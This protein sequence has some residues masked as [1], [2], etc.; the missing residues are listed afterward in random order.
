MAK[1]YLTDSTIYSVSPYASFHSNVTNKQKRIVTLGDDCILGGPGSFSLTPGE[2]ATHVIL[3]TGRCVIDD[4]LI[5]SDTILNIDLMDS[6]NFYNATGN[7]ASEDG[8]FYFCLDYT[9]SKSRP[10]PKCSVQILKP[11]ETYKYVKNVS[12]LI[13]KV[14]EVSSGVITKYYD[15]DSTDLNNVKGRV[16]PRIYAENIEILPE[17][18][19]SDIGRFV[20]VKDSSTGVVT[21]Y[22][23]YEAE[24]VVIGQ[25]GEDED[26]YLPIAS[27]EEPTPSDWDYYVGT[28]WVQVFDNPDENRI[29]ILVS[30]ETDN[31]V[32]RSTSVAIT[33]DENP[34]FD[35]DSGSGSPSFWVNQVSGEMF[36]YMQN[37]SLENIYGNQA[38]WS[39]IT[40]TIVHDVTF[41]IDPSAGDNDNQLPISDTPFLTFSRMSE[42]LSGFNIEE[43]KTVTII[44][45]EGTHSVSEPITI[46]HPDSD[47]IIIQSESPEISKTLS[48]VTAST[49]TSLVLQLD[50]FADGVIASGDYA[51]ILNTN[52]T[53]VEATQFAALCG[54]YQIT[55]VDHSANTITI[56]WD[57]ILNRG[58][59]VVTSPAGD[60]S[61]EVYILKTILTC[62]GTNGLEL[63]TG[64][65][66]GGLKNI[67]LIGNNTEDSFGIAIPRPL[68]SYADTE[69]NKSKR[70]GGS[71][72]YMKNVGIRGFGIGLYIGPG[73]DTFGEN[74]ACTSN[75]TG[76]Y[77]SGG[78][79]YNISSSH[80][81]SSVHASPI[82]EISD[83]TGCGLYFRGG[84]S[85]TDQG[86]FCGNEK[87][88][89]RCYS[90]EAWATNSICMNN[91][92]SGFVCDDRG[93]LG[94]SPMNNSISLSEPSRYYF[95]C[96][97]AYNGFVA[98][99]NS[100]LRANEY[101][102]FSN[103]WQGICAGE[104]SSIEAFYC[105]SYNN[106]D[107][108]LF[109]YDNSRIEASTKSYRYKSFNFNGISATSNATYCESGSDNIDP[110]KVVL[111]AIPEGLE[112]FYENGSDYAN[113]YAWGNSY[114]H[115]EN[116]LVRGKTSGQ[117]SIV[118][119][120]GMSSID[121]EH[122]VFFCRTLGNTNGI[123]AYSGSKV[124]CYK[125]VSFNCSEGFVSD[126]Q[127]TFMDAS[128]AVSKDHSA[129][130][131][132]S[133][134]SGTMDCYGA[135][136][137]NNDY[138]GFYAEEG[139]F[140]Y[141]Q[142]SSTCNCFYADILANYETENDFFNDDPT[143]HSIYS[144]LTS[145]QKGNSR[146]GYH[147]KTSS[148]IQCTLTFSCD[149]TYNAYGIE[150][151][152]SMHAYRARAYNS[153]DIAFHG[154]ST[155]YISLV[156][157]Y[158]ENSQ[159]SEGLRLYSNST[160]WFDRTK[161]ENCGS[162]PCFKISRRSY[163]EMSQCQAITGSYGY[164]CEYGSYIKKMSCTY[165][166][167]GTS[168]NADGTSII[169]SS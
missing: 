55:S 85:I 97:N 47:K 8:L 118:V 18:T 114:I 73:S 26:V 156:V 151:N 41:Y 43:G 69:E 125:G 22:L 149:N 58:H 121:G 53:T 98:Y 146:N 143:A 158:S 122:C 136:S 99:S 39:R 59:T 52:A 48:H 27:T 111:A 95:S 142:S 60:I 93:F 164:Q 42:F 90:S 128:M 45:P 28:V 49:P 71:I 157:C 80:S 84:Y 123:I 78:R 24:W 44:V 116:A 54:C 64:K 155:A 6:N 5:E 92:G 152:S 133:R 134:H 119:S 56:N 83:S 40:R 153:G 87:E 1:T 82:G 94:L 86:F 102:A 68:V 25:G 70:N 126:G 162:N 137:F 72:S 145:S 106:S 113:I 89:V 109:A 16:Y 67:A 61:G 148:I 105:R 4:V 163:A 35:T 38:N 20:C 165:T 9:Y 96:N 147:A 138:Y 169:E 141:A 36:L 65:Q 63:N 74:I 57:G 15:Q 17:W 13:I 30:N 159:F 120:E 76:M 33:R 115:I 88:G 104:G 66:L 46:D 23:G 32:W 112:E 166:G 51:L 144:S 135:S 139:G 81:N 3:G 29:F 131:F 12:Y 77:L 21:Y 124:Y 10:A 34:N 132:C 127:N 75:G 62:V 160:G 150:E 50:D 14:L 107:C 154:W 108:S 130:G 100:F 7:I 37:D 129:S 91:G 117:W 103:G 168:D 167:S 2:D 31:A 110:Y 161:I 140:M 79:L 101:L 11:S 19:S